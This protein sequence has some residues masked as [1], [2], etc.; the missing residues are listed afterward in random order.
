MKI[1]PKNQRDYWE[2]KTILAYLTIALQ[3]IAIILIL[4][5]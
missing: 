3:L 4:K 1:L 5:K 2:L